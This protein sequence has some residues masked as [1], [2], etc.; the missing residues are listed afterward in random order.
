LGPNRDPDDKEAGQF[1]VAFF[2]GVLQLVEPQ[3]YFTP[4]VPAEN[5][6]RQYSW[7]SPPRI[8]CAVIRPDR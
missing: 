6:V 5:Y 4:G 2:D 8:G 1:S 3:T 7:W